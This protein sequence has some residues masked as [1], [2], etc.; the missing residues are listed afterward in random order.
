MYFDTYDAALSAAIKQSK[1]QLG[2]TKL[3]IKKAYLLNTSG[4]TGMVRSD[5]TWKIGF[6]PDNPD[7]AYIYNG[8]V[9]QVEK[10]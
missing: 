9:K 3:Y 1:G 7:D 10:Q 5:N 2:D 8:Q 4:S 6:T